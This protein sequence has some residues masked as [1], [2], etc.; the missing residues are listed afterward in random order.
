MTT[1]RCDC[2]RTGAG[3]AYTPVQRLLHQVLGTNSSMDPDTIANCLQDCV[4]TAAPDLRPWV[5]LLGVVLDVTIP[6]S[7]EVAELE[8]QHRAE[9]V[10][11]LVADLLERMV[12]T[13][14]MLV[15]E[16]SYLADPASEG[17]LAAIGRREQ[18]HPW[19]LLVTRDDRPTGWIPAA[20]GRIEL[21][22]LD[23]TSSIE[24]AK[25]AT[26]DRPLPPAIAEELAMRSGGHPL[27]LRELARAAARGRTP[28]SSLRLLK[29]LPRVRSTSCHRRSVHSY[30]VPQYLAM[31]SPKTCSCRCSGTL[32]PRGREPNYSPG[33]QGS[34]CRPVT[35]FAS[36]PDS[37][38]S[39][40]CWP[41]L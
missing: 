39:R 36:S 5:S 6:A 15:V 11:E 24:L 30:G 10:P 2:E 37:S 20:T 1:L 28:T 41:A 9:R 19:L 35:S 14:V 13:P 4:T 16:D 12:P 7:P 29:S 34:L 8:E 40:L 38:G 27:L 22:P 3:T 31:S 18:Q 17:V 33:S 21:G 25:M 32:R 23:M 26:P